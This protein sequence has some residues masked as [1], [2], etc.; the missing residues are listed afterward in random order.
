MKV[1]QR[2]LSVQNVPFHG[3]KDNICMFYEKEQIELKE[4]WF[5][6]LNK[7]KRMDPLWKFAQRNH[8]YAV[9]LIYDASYWFEQPEGLPEI[10]QTETRKDAFYANSELYEYYLSL[11]KSF[12]LPEGSLGE[13]LIY[14]RGHPLGSIS[15]ILKGNLDAKT[16][17]LVFGIRNPKIKIP[18]SSDP[19]PI[20]IFEELL[21]RLDPEK[22]QNMPNYF[23]IAVESMFTSLECQILFLLSLNFQKITL[24]QP[25]VSNVR[26]L[27]AIN[28]KPQLNS[29]QILEYS[30]ASLGK[31]SEILVP[32]VFERWLTN[33]N[34]VYLG[35][36]AEILIHLIEAQKAFGKQGMTY[37]PGISYDLKRVMNFLLG[38]PFI[39]EIIKPRDFE[40]FNQ[41]EVQVELVRASMHLWS[42]AEPGEFEEDVAKLHMFIDFEK[43]PQRDW[44][45]K[46]R[47]ISGDNWGQRK[48][49]LAEIHFLTEHINPER[50]SVVFYAG[51]SP[52]DHGTFL[53]KYFD[54]IKFILIDPRPVSS[55]ILPYQKD[56][57]MIIQ[58]IFNENIAQQI[59]DALLSNTTAKDFNTKELRQIV[60]PAF[61]KSGDIDYFY[62]SDIRSD[63][64][65]VAADLHEAI[66]EQD[67]LLQSRG[68][69][70]LSKLRVPRSVGSGEVDPLAGDF[71]NIFVASMKFRHSYDNRNP[72][73][74]YEEG[75]LATQVWAPLDSTELRLWT[76]PGSPKIKYDKSAIEKIMAYHN[77][78]TRQQDFGD[79]GIEGYD[80]CH[81]CHA[82]LEVLDKFARKIRK[83]ETE[84]EV[85]GELINIGNVITE[86]LGTT[87]RE[88]IERKSKP[89]IHVLK[90]LNEKSIFDPYVEYYRA[91]TFANVKRY[92]TIE[93]GKHINVKDKRLAN[94]SF[95]EFMFYLANVHRPDPSK[96]SDAQLFDWKNTSIDPIAVP[97]ETALQEILAGN[98]FSL[99]KEQI[100]KIL[101][102]VNYSRELSFVKSVN[103]KGNSM[104]VDVDFAKNDKVSFRYVV[105]E[106]LPSFLVSKKNKEETRK[107]PEV[108]S[109]KVKKQTLNRIF[110][111]KE[112]PSKFDID[113]LLHVGPFLERAFTILTRYK[114]VHFEGMCN[115]PKNLI[116]KIHPDYICGTN[117]LSSDKVDYGAIYTDFE[118]QFTPYNNPFSREN[119]AV[120]FQK[121]LVY[122]PKIKPL[123]ISY[124]RKWSEILKT[125]E[126]LAIIFVIPE[127]YKEVLEETKNSFSEHDFDGKVFD[128]CEMKEIQSEKRKIYVM[129]TPKSD[130]AL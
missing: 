35:T 76:I 11:K 110:T 83:A 102:N 26:Y 16:I 47:N 31:T 93:L 57:V 111:R 96:P 40:R 97:V 65:N 42:N 105:S 77:V 44:D 78:V 95:K 99:K 81:D 38:K 6:L 88:H 82:E 25:S 122:P 84:E 74:E 34:N 63:V 4:F 60:H 53:I 23:I 41:D 113:Q 49:L 116:E 61:V 22:R 91:L 71:K 90:G 1:H 30:N 54:N 92:F 8:N 119:F 67:M 48:L 55:K 124:I 45:P 106:T 104:N 50:R 27:I 86:S 33:I 87:L 64:L 123:I 128:Y 24:F 103:L 109:L 37:W 18:V 101:S 17:E 29:E 39:P 73:F 100:A 7:D 108:R 118:L 2:T 52:F 70:I 125:R 127:E 115:T 15:R 107:N 112:D 62:I 130:F 69:D 20:I 114:N 68:L 14:T 89:K 56:K 32:E 117:L 66:I 94:K 98:G 19:F 75:I 10:Q 58:G 12:V 129:K 120:Q 21:Q 9:G 46:V 121:V 85:Y 3:K 51:A 43:D 126:F 79:P 72:Y 36:N 80:G 59:V 28:F 13:T 5:Y